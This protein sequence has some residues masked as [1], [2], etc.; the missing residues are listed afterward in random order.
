MV[1][2]RPQL[3]PHHPRLV[4]T[5]PSV[6][7]QN[8]H[9]AMLSPVVSIGLAAHPQ[10]PSTSSEGNCALVAIASVDLDGPR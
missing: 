10:P 8:V 4:S 7:A 1:D 2:T 9:L 5:M 6:P 3:Q